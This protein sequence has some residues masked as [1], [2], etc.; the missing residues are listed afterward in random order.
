MYTRHILLTSLS[1][2]SFTNDAGLIALKHA[3]PVQS[4]CVHAWVHIY[5]CGAYVWRPEVAGD[6]TLYHALPYSLRHGLSRSLELT[7]E[8]NLLRSE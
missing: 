4:I 7:I 2:I 3:Y 8:L 5:V 1:T 6:A